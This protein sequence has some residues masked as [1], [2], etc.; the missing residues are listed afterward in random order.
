MNNRKLFLSMVVSV[1]CIGLFL[2]GCGKKEMQMNTAPTS[3]FEGIAEIDYSSWEIGKPGG[4]ITVSLVNDPKTLNIMVADETTT[5]DV[6][7][8]VY[9]FIVARNILT[10][11]W[12]GKLVESWVISDDSKTITFTMRKGLQWSDGTPLTAEDV[13][14]T[15]NE[16]YLNDKVQGSQKDQFYIGDELAQVKLV[17]T[18]TF[19]ITT[20]V[21]YADIVS[22]AN[23]RVVP[24]H[25]LEPLIAEKGIE[26]VN[27]FWGVDADV[28]TIVGS[29]PFTIDEYVPGQRLILA[30]NPHY[31]RKD[32]K[33]NRLP[34]L[35]KINLVIVEDNNTSFLK[36]LA[37]EL[38]TM[39]RVRGEDVATL[40]EKKKEGNFE[41]YNS[42]PEASTNF[43]TINQNVN[44]VPEPKLS[45]FS[46]KKFRKALA[47]LI[48]RQTI[49][50][51]VY[52]GFATPQYS[53]V[54]RFSPLYW[55]GADEAAPK[56]SP[57]SARQL[58]DE[59]EMKD[60]DGDGIR[61][62]ANGNPVAFIMQT[63]SSNTQRVKIGEIISQ[64]MKKAGLD[65]T[66]KPGDFNTII[67]A[68]TNSYNWDMI[69][70]GL[71][72]SLQ[73]FLSGNNVYPSR[74]NLHMIEPNQESPRRDWEKQVD[75]LYI[76]NT[77]TV[78]MEIRKSTGYEMQKIWLDELPWIYTVNQAAI[79]VFKN[80]LGNIK[81]RNIEPYY[82]WMGICEFLYIK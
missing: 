29:G 55:Q 69:V 60:R 78:D 81:P 39:L 10:L 75:K 14:F 46:N 74:G 43:L 37:G 40:I 56:F 9:D 73:P 52:F 24:K 66:F 51:N 20:P 77:T 7:N 41:I 1:I 71:T 22:L 42:G 79:Y 68:L 61:E 34:Y 65:V 17:D 47:Y 53:F 28:K 19:T 76:E 44:T 54:P 57:E 48:D 8:R 49:I 3:L 32:A 45:W 36:F 30:K 25:I 23:F 13:V 50:E 63:N 11:E 31:W 70:I 6:L 18:N 33:G 35:D 58:L 38:D 82:S 59:L 4:A 67:T 16:I 21:I 15:V 62:D 27:S 5:T 26:A 64:E 80:R 2:T 72:G 12:E